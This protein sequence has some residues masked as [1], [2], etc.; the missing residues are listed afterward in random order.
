MRKKEKN[1]ST[2]KSV[3]SIQVGD[4]GAEDDDDYFEDPEPFDESASFYSMK[5]SRPLLKAIESAK[6]S[7]PTP[8]QV[9]WHFSTGIMARVA[10]WYIFKPKIPIWVNFVVSCNGRCWYFL[11][12]FG[13]CSGFFK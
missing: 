11:W 3:V 4:G 10:R 13:I 7:H 8:I 5:L 2:G 1:G 6:F 12:P 9:T